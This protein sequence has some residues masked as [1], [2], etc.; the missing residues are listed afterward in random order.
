MQQKQLQSTSKPTPS[1]TLAAQKSNP[2]PY[3]TQFQLNPNQNSSYNLNSSNKNRL[4]CTYWHLF[5]HTIDK[6]YKLIGYPLCCKPKSRT[7][8]QIHKAPSNNPLA[9]NNTTKINQTSSA[10]NLT[11][12]S[13]TLAQCHN[14]LSMLQSKLVVVRTDHETTTHIVGTC[15]PY[16][17]KDEWIISLEAS[18]HICF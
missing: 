1:L 16:K 9:A 11:L 18:T 15:F 10:S 5:G 4:V 2:S 6:C 3:H 17:T 8:N 7:N 12:D 14:I 13:E